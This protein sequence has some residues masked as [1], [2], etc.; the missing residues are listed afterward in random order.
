M[1]KASVI[2]RGW[3][4]AIALFSLVPVSAMA[5]A[6]SVLVWGRPLPRNLDPH[7]AS[8]L[9]MLFIS[10]NVYDS[11]YRYEGPASD[12][13]P[14]LVE[15]K[16]VSA[17]GKTW[18]F[19]L[20]KGV[21]FHDGKEMTADD[22]I[23]SFK[24]VLAL[25]K[26]PA[27]AFKRVLKPENITKIDSYTVK[28]VL[29]E[30]Y[31]PFLAALPLVAIVN[32]D[33]V[34]ANVKG[35]DWGQPWLSSNDAGSGAYSMVLSSYQPNI[36]LD[37][38]R[39]KDHFKGWKDNPTAFDLIRARPVLDATSRVLALLKGD[40]DITDEH[41]PI[42]QVARIENS[43]VARVEFGSP[44]RMIL[45]RMNNSKAPFD[46][47]HFR[48]CMSFAFNYDGFIDDISQGN[49]S[50]LRSPIPNG[51]WGQPDDLVHY[52]FD[53][54]KAKEECS[55]AKAEG[56][57]IDRELHVNIISEFVETRQVAELLQSSTQELGLRIKIVPDT[58][59]HVTAS[60]AT[61][62]GTPDM[63]VHY[64]GA[65]EV[66]PANWI[67]QMYDSKFAGTWKAASWYKNPKIDDLL[68]KARSE[69]SQDKRTQ[70]YNEAD[71]I[72]VADAVDIWV[73]DLKEARGISNRVQGFRFTPV[74]GGSE[75]RWTYPAVV[76]AAGQ[77]KS[78]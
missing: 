59:P 19:K 73:A 42:E 56:A 74:G 62:E 45:I 3:L 44:L 22:V 60:T 9:P 65:Y 29:E 1:I 38:A 36:R 21:K 17:D 48:K 39:F 8:D 23:Y 53:L 31:A 10:L 41:L 54:A 68:A 50:R 7:S 61:A 24:R 28:F 5:Q 20:R 67:G 16:T 58:W 63:W 11:L 71:R 57:P 15:S 14:W 46:N 77:G 64:V 75:L 51:L 25:G 2:A 55:K 12:N 33:L 27:T 35:D 78:G 26:S 43:K 32:S 47:L 70:L 13:E 37:L 40:I 66:D 72:I 30:P 49:A 34:R 4:I 69:L 76:G 6:D 52:D 18:E